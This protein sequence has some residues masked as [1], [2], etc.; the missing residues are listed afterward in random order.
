MKDGK[1]EITVSELKQIIKEEAIK[2][3]TKM[4]AEAETKKKLAI[5]ESKKA[6]LL[7]KLNECGYSE[8]D[9]EEGK[10]DEFFGRKS[11]EEYMKIGKAA[12]AASPGKARTYNA[13]A[14]AGQ[15]DRL[16]KYMLF[17]GKNP[18]VKYARWDDKIK[19]FVASGNFSSP[20]GGMPS[21]GPTGD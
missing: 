20:G 18:G 2:F 1:F 14:R 5:L 12:I 4:I 7:K 10:M 15:K 3:K 9:M 17:T 11:D 6:D 13:M 19:N 16:N 21:G 8:E